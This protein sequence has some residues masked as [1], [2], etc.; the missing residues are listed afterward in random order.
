MTLGQKVKL[1]SVHVNQS[2]ILNVKNYFGSSVLGAGR[3]DC[4]TWMDKVSRTFQRLSRLSSLS[5]F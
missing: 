4:G 5:Q 2:N 3:A 1:P